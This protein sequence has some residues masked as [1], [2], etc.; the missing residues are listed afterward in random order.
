MVNLH[1]KDLYQHLHHMEDMVVNLPAV[2]INQVDIPLLVTDKVHNLLLLEGH[3]LHLEIIVLHL[4]RVDM[5]DHLQIVTTLPHLVVMETKDQV[6]AGVVAAA[7][8]QCHLAMDQLTGEVL[9]VEIIAVSC[10][11]SSF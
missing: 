4:L 11:F 6:V 9:G 8:P 10:K 3:H 2:M 7:I 5:E 1:P